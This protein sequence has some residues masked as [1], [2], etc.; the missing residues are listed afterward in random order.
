MAFSPEYISLLK[1]EGTSLPELTALTAG[2]DCSFN[3]DYDSAQRLLSEGSVFVDRLL[4]ARFLR[5]R[6]G[7]DDL[8]FLWSIDKLMR[9]TPPIRTLYTDVGPVKELLITL[10]Q[11]SKPEDLSSTDMG[12]IREM[13]GRFSDTRD[14]LQ[15]R[16]DHKTNT[17]QYWATVYNNRR[18]S[19]NPMTLGD[20][21][22]SIRHVQ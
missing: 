19:S 21:Y 12:K 2:I 22:A 5:G 4:H 1:R 10:F 9:D 15:Q 6:A 7:R 14:L 17:E 3:R 13:R 20:Y 16:A 18:F 11:V 8:G